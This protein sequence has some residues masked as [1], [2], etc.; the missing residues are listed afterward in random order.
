MHPLNSKV[1]QGLPE[2]S[3]YIPSLPASGSVL[4]LLVAILFNTEIHTTTNHFFEGNSGWLMLL[5][6]DL[7]TGLRTTL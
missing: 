1:D 2:L 3:G 7:Y 4:S 5:G 6:I